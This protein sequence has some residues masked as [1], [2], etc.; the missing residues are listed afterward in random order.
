MTVDIETYSRLEFSKLL[1]SHLHTCPSDYLS[2]QSQNVVILSDASHHLL[3][4]YSHN[5]VDSRAA[6][7]QLEGSKEPTIAHFADWLSWP[8]VFFQAR[9]HM[10]HI[11]PFFQSFFLSFFLSFSKLQCLTLSR[12]VK[13]LTL[14]NGNLNLIAFWHIL[15]IRV[16][17]YM[18]EFS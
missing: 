4:F 8:L 9:N 17:T 5:P 16:T 6:R 18:D 2:P 1:S 3:L 7:Q 10:L 14:Q 13:Q 11:I 12:H 15:V